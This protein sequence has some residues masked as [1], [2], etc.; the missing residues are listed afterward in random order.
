VSVKV[1]LFYLP[2]IGSRGEI[3][4]G[5]AGLRG[6][7]YGRMLAELAEQAKLA[8]DL[9]Y[10]SI[11][12]TE[13]HFHV[14][15]FEISNNPVLLDLFIG[16]QTK[17]IRVGQLGI[18]L[19]ADNP[20]RVAE[21]IAMLDHM[22]GG[23]ANAGFARGYQRRWVDVMAQQTHGIHGA[24]PHKHDAVDAANRAAFEECFRIVKAA[25]T[26]DLLEYQG[27]YWRIPPGETPWTL[28]ATR[29]FGAGVVD[30]VV[31]SVAVVPKPLQKPHP[32]IFQPFASSERSIRWCAAEG[33][34]AIL[35]PLH[36]RL[37]TQLF[38][39]YAEASGRPLGDGIGVLRDVVI[40]DTDEEAMHLWESSGAFCGAAWFAPFGFS[41]GLADP[42]TGMAP[43]LFASS[44][45]L[46]G[47]V[48]SVTRQLERLLD[49]LPV[50]W[51]FAW[52]YNG[53]IPHGKLMRSIER[54]ATEVL[55][56]VAANAA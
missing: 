16:L 3:E 19:P 22:T 13:H 36:P 14:E 4:Q 48:D 24:L 7:L 50:S 34:T 37:E 2:S 23:R 35:P 21:D 6:D 45:A 9:A 31:R 12:F 28:E 5:R 44:L 43:D 27:R 39:V 20:I 33:V 42:A 32:P 1:S 56:R 30:D 17:R 11:S 29:R 55:P 15:G 52:T 49:R 8:D 53:L 38:E 10:D 51:L 26:G 40:A 47:S 41:Q 18:V 46:V 25:W 54:F